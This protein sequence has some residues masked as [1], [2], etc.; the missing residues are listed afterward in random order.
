MYR[1]LSQIVVLALLTVLQ[2]ISCLAADQAEP[3]GE[4]IKKSLQT[5]QNLRAKCSGNYSYTVS[6][7]SWVGVGH[8][9]Q[10][11]VRNNKVVERTYSEFNR[12]VAVFV[13][14][15]QGPPKPPGEN[16][17][18]KG[19]QLGSH[20]KGATLKTLDDLYKDAQNVVE[21][22]LLP[23]QRLYLIFDKQ[24]L[25]QSCFYVDTRIA[26]DAPRTGVAIAG[27]QL[28]L[29]KH[30]AWSKYVHRPWPA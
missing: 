1:A 17:T 25:L 15:G 27:I 13:Q 11:V 21:T 3:A 18:E 2:G 23:Q 7:Q 6:F 30:L 5:W 28:E 9:T 26:D 12:N 4:Q 14:P 8:R 16:W 29:P 22:K 20:T 19:G 10:I 24:G